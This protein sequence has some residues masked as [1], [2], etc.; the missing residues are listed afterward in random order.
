MLLNAEIYVGARNGAESNLGL[1][2]VQRLTVPVHYKE[3]TVAMD[4][5]FMSVETCKYLL[6]KNTY[7]LGTVRCNRKCVPPCFRK[8]NLK[9]SVKTQNRVIGSAEYVFCTSPLI[10]LCSYIPKRSKFVLL[11]SS[12]VGETKMVSVKSKNIVEKKPFI[13]HE[14]NKQKCGVDVF[15]RGITNFSCA[16]TTRRWPLRMFYFL[17]DIACWNAYR[18]H[19]LKSENSPNRKKYLDRF[20]FMEQLSFE[21]TFEKRKKVV[22]EKRKVEV[23]KLF[24][25]LIKE[26][27]D[28]QMDNQEVCRHGSCAYCVNKSTNHVKTR[29]ANCRCFICEKHRKVLC[30]EC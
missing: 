28:V 17:I 24:P 19:L 1:H 16:R 6:E 20:R 29:C 5:F 9:Q 2:V 25:Q 15:N 11:M 21:L 3:A 27:L 26:M 18:L 10:M 23:R 7:A 30:F 14:Y 4:N 8:E 12:I 13:V 22:L